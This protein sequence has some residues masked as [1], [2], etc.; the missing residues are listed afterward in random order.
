[1]AREYTLEFKGSA[2]AIYDANGGKSADDKERARAMT[3]AAKQLQIPRNTLKRWVK[4]AD[5]IRNQLV[6]T[7]TD[8]TI[9]QL[10]AEKTGILTDELRS[11]GFVLLAMGDQVM[12]QLQKK[13]A[14]MNTAELV[15]TLR[16]IGYYQNVTLSRLVNLE[17]TGAGAGVK[18]D[19]GTKRNDPFFQRA[20][21]DRE[22]AKA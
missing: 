4:R 18:V 13:L 16:A 7:L 15:Q 22:E 11:T 12:T 20:F 6:S 10:R 5:H 2:L 14:E 17:S 3:F 9:A 19:D 1:M 8:D 21:G